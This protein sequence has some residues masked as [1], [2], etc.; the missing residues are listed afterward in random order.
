MQNGVMFL[1]H[2]STCKKLADMHEDF[3]AEQ[4]KTQGDWL[5]S[6]VL[7]FCGCTA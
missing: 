7:C 5:I 4:S 1:H 3:A 6:F 2:Q